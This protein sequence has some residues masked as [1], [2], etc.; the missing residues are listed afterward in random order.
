VRNRHALALGH[1]IDQQIREAHR[2]D[3]A[4]APKRRLRL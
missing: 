2:P 4:A 3:P 1:C